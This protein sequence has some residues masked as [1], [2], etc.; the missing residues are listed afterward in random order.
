VDEPAPGPAEPPSQQADPEPVRIRGPLFADE[1]GDLEPTDVADPEDAQDAEPT[2]VVHLGDQRPPSPRAETV[3]APQPLA[4]DEPT[5]RPTHAAAAAGPEP[6]AGP[7]TGPDTGADT[8]WAGGLA[9]LVDDDYPEEDERRERPGWLVPALLGALVLLLVLSAYGI[10]RIFSS[11]VGDAD[12]STEEPDGVVLGDGDQQGGTEGGQEGGQGG[13]SDGPRNQQKG[14]YQGRTDQATIGGATASCQAPASVD[15]AGNEVAYPPTNVYD[16]DLTTAWRCN[17]TGVGQ[18]LTL[19]LAEAGRIGEVGLV[20]GYAK[21]DPRS[22]VDR[23]AENNRLTRV[24]WTFADGASMVQRLD[25]SATNREL[26]TMRIPVTES[27]SVVLEVLA[28][29]RGPRN[30]MAVSEVRVGRAAE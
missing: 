29:T 21:T 2:Q 23:Y 3:F 20:P 28:S 1:P 7:E 13:G 24:R 22:G 26:Q 18:S 12:V 17:G 27:D 16:G 11:S 10:G 30:T 15:A 4:F 25:G 5:A 6:E 8:G 19:T 14:A 9:D